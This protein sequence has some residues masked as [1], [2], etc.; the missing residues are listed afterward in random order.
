[1]KKPMGKPGGNTDR[2]L[3]CIV[4]EQ[5]IMDKT[6][7]GMLGIEEDGNEEEKV[8]E[9]DMGG[10]RE[11]THEWCMSPPR[12]SKTRANQSI[13]LQLASTQVPHAEIVGDKEVT[14]EWNK[15]QE[16]KSFDQYCE[17]I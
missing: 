12:A 11:E 9:E 6:Y 3:R 10:E 16:N 4:I 1:M 17:R 8:D 2:V 5:K 7:S 15:Q 14:T 13:C